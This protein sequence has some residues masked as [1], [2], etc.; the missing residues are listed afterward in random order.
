[1]QDKEIS[2][3]I[4]RQKWLISVY[5]CVTVCVFLINILLGRK[6]EIQNRYLIIYS[7][8]SKRPVFQNQFGI[9]IT[10]FHK[11]PILYSKN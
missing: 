5:P 9:W 7:N 8:I 4:P 2:K 3:T 11:K 10:K 6:Y 1:M